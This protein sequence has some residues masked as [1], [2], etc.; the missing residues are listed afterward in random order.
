[1]NKEVRIENSH[2]DNV[3]ET[4]GAARVD[5]IKYDLNYYTACEAKIK[6]CLPILFELY[7]KGKFLPYMTGSVIHKCLVYKPS[8]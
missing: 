5:E 7:R 4:L 3:T 1:M 8:C 2:Q 6:D